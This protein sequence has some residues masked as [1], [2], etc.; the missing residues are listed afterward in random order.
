MSSEQVRAFGREVRR[1]RMALNRSLDK[2]GEQAGMTANYLGNVEGGK[3]A[4]GPSLEAAFRIANAL[5]TDI[6]EL[7]G[8][9][10]GVSVE[11]LEAARLFE[12]LP[13]GAK[14]PLIELLRALAEAWG[15]RKT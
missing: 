10:R 15:G 8:E 13:P 4:R 1:R 11:G 7:V 14:R 9:N 3:R 6:S 5:G 12:G 2:L